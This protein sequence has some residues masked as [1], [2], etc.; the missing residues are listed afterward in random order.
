MSNL[1]R[2][3]GERPT[4]PARGDPP[5]KTPAATKLRI[6]SASGAVYVFDRNTKMFRQL[7]HS[8]P[9]QGLNLTGGL[10]YGV[11]W[12]L[13]PDPPVE[14]ENLRIWGPSPATDRPRLIELYAI[15]IEEWEDADTD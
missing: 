12:S 6:T 14:G 1:V 2:M 11:Y 13:R 8:T 3:V 4:T 10:T 5:V 7:T 9:L 15:H